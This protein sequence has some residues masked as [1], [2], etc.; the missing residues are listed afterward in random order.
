VVE[1]R[2]FDDGGLVTNKNS[3]IYGDFFPIDIYIYIYRQL[4]R[5]GKSDSFGQTK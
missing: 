2:A 5:W 1:N 4:R 3:P